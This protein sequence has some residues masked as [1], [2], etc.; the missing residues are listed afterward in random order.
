MTVDAWRDDTDELVDL[1]GRG[2]AVTSGQLVEFGPERAAVLSLAEV[3]GRA[4]LTGGPA[5]PT[6][7]QL[8]L[9]ID[10]Q[11]LRYLLVCRTG[12]IEVRPGWSEDVPVLIRQELPELVNAVFGQPGR[13]ETTREIVTQDLAGPPAWDADDP[14]VVA[15]AHAVSAAHQ[16]IAAVNQRRWGLTELAVRFGSD[17]WG[18][19][20]YTPHYERYFDPFRDERISLL[21]IGVGGYRDPGKGGAS[22]RMWK[23]YFRRG[24]IHGLDIY[25]KSGIDG[26]RLRTHRGDQGDPAYL[27]GLA[28][29]IGPLDIVIDDGSHLN[30]HVVTSFRALFP[31]V[32]PGGLYVIED[33]LTAY[34]PGWGGHDG[35]QPSTTGTSIGLVKLLIDGLHHQERSGNGIHPTWTDLT[36]TAVHVH[37]NLVVIEKGLNTEQGAPAWVPRDRDPRTWLITE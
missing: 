34:W 27:S 25:D 7:V 19:H 15:H 37:H 6:T 33:V 30:E 17:K 4:E 35:V 5:E 23:H 14:A 24:M 26:P 28:D 32:R 11:R 12:R 9:G 8:D 22:L 3:A 21:E 10:G 18:S 29:E 31:H 16:V 13:Y 1:V 36:V 2:G 20:W